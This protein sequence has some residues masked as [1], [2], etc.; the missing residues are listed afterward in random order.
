M[1]ENTKKYS[2]GLWALR[3]TA[4]RFVPGGYESKELEIKKA[5][6]VAGDI[7]GIQGVDFVSD[8]FDEMDLGELENILAENDLQPAGVNFH[9][10]R[11]QW[12]LGSLTNPEVKKRKSA[13]KYGKE[14]LDKAEKLGC[15]EVTFWLGTDGF[16]Y[17]FQIDYE[18]H[19]GLLLD[20]ITELARY[21]KELDIGLEYKLKEPRKHQTIG[22]AIKALYATKKVNIENVGVVVDF[23]H[24][25]MSKENAAES[26]SLVAG[27]GKLTGVHF[28]DAYREWDDDLVPGSVNLWDSLEFL[29][30]LDKVSYEGWISFDIFPFRMQN[31]RAVETCVKNTDKMIEILERIDFNTIKQH[32]DNMDIAEIQKDLLAVL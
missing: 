21:K 8:V 16:D 5:I 24:A 12:S 30:Y 6:E 18:Q 22:T 25:L 20:G 32:Q 9:S 4:D 28:N 15:E 31:R 19:W 7:V 29:Y 2:I 14:V 27:E 13:I 1:L 26:I 17:P 3:G 11:R 23:G 10:W